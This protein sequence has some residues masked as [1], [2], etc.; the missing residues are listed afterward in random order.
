MDVCWHRVVNMSGRF[1]YCTSI[2]NVLSVCWSA[3]AQRIGSLNRCVG[4]PI[5]NRVKTSKKSSSESDAKSVDE[6]FVNMC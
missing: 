1:I 6:R 5:A 3:H 2:G 4:K